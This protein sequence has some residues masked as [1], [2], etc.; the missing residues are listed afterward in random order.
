MLQLR[1]EAASLS[2]GVS[3]TPYPSCAPI[4]SRDL[5]QPHFAVM[6]ETGLREDAQ[7]NRIGQANVGHAGHGVTAGIEGSVDLGDEPQNV[8]LAAGELAQHGQ[9]LREGWF[10]ALLVEDLQVIYDGDR[11]SGA[12]RTGGRRWWRR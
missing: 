10:A 2:T 6:Q 5:Q 8:P 4:G 1:L 11:A 12:R 9:L 7:F 3:S